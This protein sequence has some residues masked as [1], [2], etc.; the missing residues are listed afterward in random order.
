MADHIAGL[1]GTTIPDQTTQIGRRI[2]FTIDLD[3]ALTD[4]LTYTASG[5]PRR[6]HFD[7]V[8]RT[9]SWIP[10]EGQ[11]GTWVITFVATDQSGLAIAV[12]VRVRVAA[13]A[14]SG[15]KLDAEKLRRIIDLDSGRAARAKG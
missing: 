11:D 4:S 8:T 10:F 7:P 3:P 13:R 1:E 15:R 2:S 5:L 9:F 14:A 6:A 12:P